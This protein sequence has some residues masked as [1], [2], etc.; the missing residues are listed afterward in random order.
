MH[1]YTHGILC[2]MYDFTEAISLANE[3]CLIS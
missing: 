3:H 2:A 1:M